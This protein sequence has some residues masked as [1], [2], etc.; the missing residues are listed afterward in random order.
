MK[1]PDSD[2]YCTFMKLSPLVRM[3]T[4]NVEP[5]N[6]SFL[7]HNELYDNPNVNSRCSVQNDAQFDMKLETVQTQVQKGES[8]PSVTEQGN[9]SGRIPNQVVINVRCVIT[10]AQNGPCS[11]IVAKLA[12]DPNRVCGDVQAF[13]V[14][15]NLRAIR[16]LFRIYHR[17]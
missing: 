11:T 14:R 2:R 9:N 10:K 12:K 5:E 17:R 15:C 13:S 6:M 7:S 3:P 16:S 8:M 1:F 4:R